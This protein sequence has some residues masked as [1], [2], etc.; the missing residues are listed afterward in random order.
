MK[1]YYFYLARSIRLDLYTVQKHC[2]W[3]YTYTSPWKNS[4]VPR[5]PSVI[6][7]VGAKTGHLNYDMESIQYDSF[8]CYIYVV[9]YWPM[10]ICCSQG[11]FSTSAFKVLVWIFLLYPQR[12]APVASPF[13]PTLQRS[14]QRATSRR[15]VNRRER[16]LPRRLGTGPTVYVHSQF[17][18]TRTGSSWEVVFYSLPKWKD[19]VWAPLNGTNRH[20][21]HNWTFRHAPEATI[22]ISGLKRHFK[23]KAFWKKWQ[24]RGLIVLQSLQ[25][26]RN[27]MGSTI[28]QGYTALMPHTKFDPVRTGGLWE[29]DLVSTAKIETPLSPRDNSHAQ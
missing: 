21:E 25:K 13:G 20:V 10:F 3:P 26:G 11:S 22:S 19:A 29:N 17:C 5:G 12:S 24:I 18:P 15:D 4:P 23:Q 1:N 28:W 8:C 27:L 6:S 2:V 9:T 14:P 7:P 16:L